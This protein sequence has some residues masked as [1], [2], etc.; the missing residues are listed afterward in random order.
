M[1]LNLPVGYFPFDYFWILGMLAVVM[2][3]I[4][5]RNSWKKI[6][7]VQPELRKGYDQLLLGYLVFF[8]IPWIVM[9]IGMIFGGI[10]S[11]LSF[12]KPRNGSIFILAFYISIVLLWILGAWWL[13]FKGGAEFLIEHPGSM[14]STFNSPKQV[15]FFYAVTLVFGIVAMILMWSW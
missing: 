3:T 4:Y 10:P 12:F 6:V 14:N 9:G 11:S 5:L 15:K 7:E 8:N 2:G 1:D 13:Y